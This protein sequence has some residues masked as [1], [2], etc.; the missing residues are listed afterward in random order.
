M[1]R[2]DSITGKAWL[3]VA[4]GIVVWSTTTLEMGTLRH[5]GPAFLPTLSGV[6]IASL[7]IVVLVQAKRNKGQKTG[8]PFWIK[9]SIFRIIVMIGILLSYAFVLEHLGFVAS[10]F[11]LMLLIVT[12]VARASLL[13][14]IIE[15]SI[16][17]GGAYLLFGYLLSIPLPK[18]VLGM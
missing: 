7:A 6:F 4:I 13:A 10:T 9:G 2:Y 14:G 15:S 11:L 3:L 16:A 8:D 1:N 17:T 12:Q 5:P 18:G